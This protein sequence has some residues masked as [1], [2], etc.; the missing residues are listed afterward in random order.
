MGLKSKSVSNGSNELN[1]IGT[2]TSLEGTIETNGSLRID[3]RVK[4]TVTGT[5]VH[6][7]VNGQFTGRQIDY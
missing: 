5:G 6:L 1:F 3:G 2:G 7:R 4:G